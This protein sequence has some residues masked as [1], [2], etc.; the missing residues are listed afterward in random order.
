VRAAV[1]NL[2]CS[3]LM[4]LGT[5]WP[6][7][8]YIQPSRLWPFLL[9]GLIGIPLGVQLLAHANPGTLK[10]ALGAVIAAFGT[11]V[12]AAPRLPVIDAGGRAADAAIGFGG[13]VLGG[14]GG[15]SGILPTIWTQLRGWPKDLA[16]GVYQPFILMAQFV[17]LILIGIVALDTTA[18][19]LFFATL[20]PV[21]AGA[22]IG[23][24]IYGRLNDWTFRR[25]LAALL[26]VSGVALIV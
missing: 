1:L 2:G 20:P 21:L 10:V 9:G 4:Q 25:F 12:L 19:L 5:I 7:R 3:L 11:Y 24:N 15:Y 18:V 22:V 14:L 23:W 16:R 17:T 26:V 8:H 6:L 13:G